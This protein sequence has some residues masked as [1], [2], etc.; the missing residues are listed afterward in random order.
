MT[1]KDRIKEIFSRNGLLSKKLEN[2]EY[3]EEQLIMALSVLDAVE[4]KKHFLCEAGTG[5]GKSLAYLVPLAIYSLEY[6]KKIVISTNTKYLQ[7]QLTE[8]EIPFIQ[9]ELKI[10]VK[11]SMMMGSANYLCLRKLAE[12]KKMQTSLL[13]EIQF[14]RERIIDWA[15]YT[16]TGLKSEIICSPSIWEEVNREIDMCLSNKCPFFNDCFYFKARKK[17]QDSNIIIANHAL[18]FS[19]MALGN[20]LLPPYDIILFD[21]AHNLPESAQNILDENFSKISLFWLLSKIYNP[22]K[23]TGFLIKYNFSSEILKNFEKLSAQLLG[24]SNELWETL[25]SMISDPFKGSKKILDRKIFI[26]NMLN[27]E[28]KNILKFL[29]DLKEEF[30]PFEDNE[31][32]FIWELDNHINRFLEFHRIYENFIEHD[33]NEYVYW[34]ECVPKNVGFDVIC[35]NTPIHINDIL[36]KNLF[37]VKES[38]ILTSA[39]LSTNKNFNYIKKEIGL[40]QARELI[41]NSPFDYK[42]QMLFYL[43]NVPAPKKD[44]MYLYEIKVIEEIKKIISLSKGQ[45]LILFTNYS[46]MRKVYDELKNVFTDLNV[47]KQ[48]EEPNMQLIKKLKEDSKTILLGTYTFWEGVDIQ[49][50]ALKCL[51]MVKLPFTPPDE[52]I[53]IAKSRYLKSLGKNPFLEIQLPYAIIKFKQGFGRLIRHKSDKGVFALLDFRIYSKSYGKYFLNSLPDVNI[54][55]KFEEVKSFYE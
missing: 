34:F 1:L 50:E 21:E 8:K 39:T 3:R 28:I 18:V 23:K 15:F 47:I 12:L 33:K 32:K 5:I 38:V 17:M 11:V 26:P 9:N 46:F 51:I 20:I 4:K 42:K 30:N 36:E 27:E 43:P 24:K 44:N 10:P 13:N 37:M 14:E 53:I 2:Y 52:P 29:N 55:H 48:G 40:S 7:N 25:M 31:E 35:H 16:K 45:T 19:D 6:E 54:V 49:G 41:L 22:Q